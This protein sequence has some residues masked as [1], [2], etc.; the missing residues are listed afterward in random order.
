M[1]ERGLEH[2][3]DYEELKKESH[4]VKHFCDVH[5]EEDL[6]S[7]VFGCRIVKQSRTAFNRQVNEM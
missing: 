1:Y 6:D 4:M 2:L 3:R 5:P 7:V